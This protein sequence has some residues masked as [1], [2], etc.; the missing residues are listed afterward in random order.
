[1]T[2]LKFIHITDTHFVPPGR[3]LYGLDP[4][5]RLAPAIDYVNEEHS[6]AA[7]VAITG[8]LAHRGE[9]EAYRSL[10]GALARLSV[11]WHAVPG[12]HDDRIALRTV[13]PEIPA[14]P[15]G[16][17]QSALDIGANRFV[18]LDSVVEGK[19]GG[20]FCAE[21]LEWLDGVL[22]TAE[23]R[24]TFLFLH[25]AP[26]TLGIPNLDGIGLANAAEFREIVA[27]HGN[28]RHMFFGHVH[29]AAHGCWAGVPFSTLRSMV[30]QSALVFRPLPGILDCLEPPGL[31]VVR[32]DANGDVTVNDHDFLDSSPRFFISGPDAADEEADPAL[33]AVDPAARAT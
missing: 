14:L 9:A 27:R 1:M 12:N 30:N 3:R 7:F 13:F 21:R 25:H 20:L 19:P 23:N 8:D 16:F 28:V 22:A 32:I 10:A 24:G 31:A 17:L 11:P 29:R 33:T 6:D 5:E 26:V 4:A 18:F 2:S 15:G